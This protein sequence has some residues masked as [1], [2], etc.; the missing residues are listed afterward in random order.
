M[1]PSGYAPLIVVAVLL[2]GSGP[3]AAQGEA[4]HAA[5]A[6]AA[7]TEVIR[8]GYAA[9]AGAADDLQGKMD[10]LCNAPSA[11]SLDQ[12]KQAFAATVA[13]WSKVEILRFGPVTQDHRFERLFFWPDPKGIGLKQVQQALAEKDEDI[14]LPDELAAKSVAIQGLPALEYLLYGDGAEVLAKERQ[15]VG[16]NSPPEV[17]TEGAFRCGFALAV[18][19]NIDRIARAVVEDWREGSAYEKAFLGPVPDD[20]I[21]HTAKE[22]TLDLFKSFTAGI[23]L[24]RDQKLSKPLGPSPAEAK[25][26]LAAF[27]RSGLTFANAAGNLAGVRTLFAK[28]GFAQVVAN[29]SAGV[30]NSI[31]FD[32]DHAIEVLRGIDL[33]MAEVANDDDM[34]AKIEAL[35]VALKSAAQTAGDMIARGA[36]L[37]FGFN[38]M[39]GD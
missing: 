34:R 33:P 30:E 6:G 9:F 3:P 17:D 7:L 20:P 4:D 1:R 37:A 38:A 8:P 24:V 23:E 10:A 11:P 21:Y 39:D 36:G 28:G 13:A 14:G 19:T 18:A 15:I 22:V 5:I 31:L 32:L 35:R 2:G 26:K 25:P 16:E 29:E 27:W 12:A